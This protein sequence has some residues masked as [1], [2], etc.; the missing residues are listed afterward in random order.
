[1][2]KILLPLLIL[3]FAVGTSLWVVTGKH[4]IPNTP[5]SLAAKA[6]AKIAG[7]STRDSD[8]DGL[9][10]WEEATIGSDP[11][12]ADTDHDGYLDGE[13]MVSG[14]SPLV[15]AP[16]D[17][18]AGHRNPRPLPQTLSA[19][20]TQ[21]IAGTVTES[22]AQALS[23]KGAAGLKNPDDIA[24]LID[25]AVPEQVAAELQKI[26]NPAIDAS[27]FRI[28]NDTAKFKRLDYLRSVMRI[29][30]GLKARIPS[31]ESSEM[32]VISAAISSNT[33]DQVLTYRDLYNQA[34][35]EITQLTVPADLIDLQREIL[36]ILQVLATTH[37]SV[38]DFDKDPLKT[39]LALESLS[40]VQP[41]FQRLGDLIMKAVH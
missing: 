8:G 6:K 5:A 31:P 4:T 9:F 30:E 1:M 19:A 38:A 22:V 13:E 2:K 20:I 40:S 39:T 18:Q 23:Q 16:D 35:R 21:R 34:S 27:T 24:R 10:D 37:Q 33:F 32:A 36:S 12:R 15:R 25:D 3:F 14:Y 7:N 26:I 11:E 28:D 41:R 29:L 17:V